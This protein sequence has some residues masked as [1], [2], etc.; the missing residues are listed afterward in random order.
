MGQTKSLVLLA[1]AAL[2]LGASAAMAQQTGSDEV[3]ATVA[4]MLADAE[5]RSSLLSSGDAGHD[6]RFFIAGDGFR[7]NISGQIQARYYAN[8]SEE[9]GNNDGFE[10][11]FE[12]RRVKL[13]FQGDINK[14][15]FYRVRGSFSNG[16]GGNFG[17]EYGYAGYKFANGTRMTMGQFKLPLLREEL[18]GD[19]RQLAVER[20][21]TNYVFT[22]DYSQGIMLDYETETWR[23]AGAFSDGLATAGTNFT[24][25]QQSAWI[26]SGDGLGEADY[27]FTG[28]FEYMFSG[29]WKMFDDFTSAKGQDFGAM[30]GAAAHWQES[31]N[32]ND[33]TDVD[34]DTAQ[35]TFDVSVEGDSWNVFGA[36]IYRWS[37]FSALG[38]NSSDQSDYGW[39][40]QGGWR[41]AENTELFARY[42]A[43]VF[44]E[45]NAQFANTDTFNFV[46]FGL[47]QYYAGHAAKATL[48]VLWA[49]DGTAET[50]GD[51]TNALAGQGLI[52]QA[53]DNEIVL[54]AQFQ[55]LF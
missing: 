15:W 46:T 13:N 49:L 29:G 35:L 12:M 19:D 5:T 38:G 34:T 42:D 17:L 28:R 10:S 44:D 52:G 32:T 48:D 8:F 3:R 24:E 2:S 43:V 25:N 20:S 22:Q 41:F 53:E 7:L 31:A 6:G 18:V 4:E 55:L 30:I 54:R 51:I 45:D 21:V 16:D 1:G 27:A 40:L 39:V 33:P 9:E 50:G 14:D 37:D 26:A 11:G 47:N 23:V 36:F